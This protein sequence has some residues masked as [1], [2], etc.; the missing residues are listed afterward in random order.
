MTAFWNEVIVSC[1]LPEKLLPNQGCNFESQLVKELCKLAQIW[2]C[3]WHLII[4]KL[5]ANVKCSPKLLSAW[6]VHWKPETSTTGKTIFSH[7][8]MHA[9]NCTKNNATDFCPYYL[10]YRCM[11]RLPIDFQLGLTSPQSDEHS[12]NKFMVRLSTQLWWCYKL[13]IQHQHKEST[14]QKWQYDWKMR[15]SRLKPGD[16]CLVQQKA[17]GG[18]TR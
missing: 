14:C 13:A 7:A 2:R 10:M 6:L 17:F 9:Y 5:T 8:C 18:N 11:P 1:S 12:H 3:K 15:A 4:Q 16:L